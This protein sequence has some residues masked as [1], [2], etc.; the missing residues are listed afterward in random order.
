MNTVLLFYIAFSS[1][2]ILASARAV[3]VS[4]HCRRLPRPLEL[5]RTPPILK[6]NKALRAAKTFVI[7]WLGIFLFAWLREIK[8][9][10]DEQQLIR[11]FFAITAL[12]FGAVLNALLVAKFNICFRSEGDTIL[13]QNRLYSKKINIFPGFSSS[14]D[15]GITLCSVMLFLAIM[16][17]I[18]VPFISL[19]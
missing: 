18:A 11:G 10:S 14:L 12:N 19:G 16:L 8:I 5:L 15:I 17:T 7:C 6:G 4:V 1:L 9:A 2:V 3:G 13:E